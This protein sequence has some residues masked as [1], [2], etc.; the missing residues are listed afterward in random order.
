MEALAEQLVPQPVPL[1]GGGGEELP[2]G[3]APGGERRLQAALVLGRRGRGP[4]LLPHQLPQPA[5]GAVHARPRPLPGVRIGV[6]ARTRARPGHGVEVARA[7]G[8]GG[9]P[10]GVRQGLEVPADRRL[11]ELQH[12]TE[13]GDGQ[14]VPVQQQ[15]RAAARGLGERAQLVEDRRRRAGGDHSS[16]R[17]EG[18]IDPD[19]RSSP[20]ASRLGTLDLGLGTWDFGLGTSLKPRRRRRRGRRTPGASSRPRSGWPGCAP[21]APGAGC[22]P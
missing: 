12:T 7:F 18:Y 11:G 15:Q 21:R 19:G 6:R 17:M 9:H 13:L 5:G 3:R 16:S 20:P 10:A 8:P 4:E 1:P 2:R 22:A 14:L